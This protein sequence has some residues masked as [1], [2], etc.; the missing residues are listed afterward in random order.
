MGLAA[1]VLGLLYLQ[2]LEAKRSADRR[3]GIAIDE[4][5]GGVVIEE[6]TPAS[7]A[8]RAGLRAGDRLASMAGVA[9]T[10]ESDY[11]PV[12][13]HFTRGR[14]V[15]YEVVRNGVT[16]TLTVFPGMAAP[17]SEL[18]V[19]ALAVLG[20]L[21]L[22]LMTLFQRARDLRARL[23]LLFS[24]AVALELAFPA[25][26]VGNAGLDVVST[27]AF[28]LLTGTEIGL[29]LHLASVIPERPAWLARRRWVIP[30]FYSAGLLLAGIESSTFLADHFG[31][32]PFPWSAEQANAFLNSF[33]LPVWAL[34]VAGL[35]ASQVL[36]YPQ[37]LGRHQAGLVLA[38]EMPWVAFMTLNGAMELAGRSLPD[39]T[40][41]LQPL[42][43]LC[44]PV[45][46]FVAIFR[47]NLFDIE[48]VVRRGLVYTALTGSLV[49]VFYA[50]LGAGSALFSQWLEE[51][52]SVLVVSAAT[53]LLGL[54]FSPLRHALQRVIDRRFFPERYAQRQ[55]LAALAG[56]L[57][58]FGKVPLMGKHLASQ[59][60]EIFATRAATL[61]VADPESQVLVAVASTRANPEREFDQSFLISSEDP[62]VEALRRG[63]RPR[64]ARELAL[65]S[66]SLAQRLGVFE[67]DLVVPVMNQD[68]LVGVV[69]LGEK[70]SGRPYLAEEIELLN[71]LSHHV[72]TVFENARLFESATHD[73]LTGLLRREA[74][75]DHLGRE[76]RRAVRYARPLTVGMADLD[77]FKQAN[78]R[79]GHIAGDTLL[80]LVAQALA[81]GWRSADCVGRY[82][83]EEFLVVLPETDLEG[84]FVVAEKI[85]AAVE[86]IHLR[87]DDGSSLRITISIGIATI[88]DAAGAGGPSVESLIAAADRN[89]LRAKRLGRNRLEPAPAARMEATRRA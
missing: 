30:G 15:T 77:H 85:R 61:L 25:S 65:K 64:P 67:T 32:R 46:V 69:L 57:P 72:G 24:L 44:F 79:Y 54:L 21:A 7:P 59:L 78:D 87:M 75:L 12:A 29:E 71:L 51:G 40:D 26:G 53:L 31:L 19:G 68:D 48:A 73:S 89:L 80:K 39:W 14:A 20:Y 34:A 9:I 11:D 42:I 23:L 17:W 38:G 2:F 8:A 58:T 83:G 52:S 4:R 47:Y 22:A 81:A 5:A 36:T 49:L 82:G 27:V 6:V 33:G 74:I 86:A 45:A 60:C 16:R 1:L 70:Q 28:F 3:I 13:A 43:L 66:A 76:V 55:R 56:E 37:P 63:R 35:L 18:L 10:K 41:L 84:A 88:A 50:A 62:G